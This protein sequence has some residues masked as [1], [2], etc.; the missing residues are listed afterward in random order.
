MVS[1]FDRLP[2]LSCAGCCLLA[3]CLL[4]GAA[5]SAA[6][7][8]D[9][10]ESAE[11]S[12]Q[13][14]DAD[15]PV[16]IEK[17]QRDF[18]VARSGSASEH[19]AITAGRGTFV[20]LVYP[21]HHARVIAEWGPS[22]WVQADRPGMQF[23]ARVVLPRTQ[24]PRNGAP[25]TTLLRGDIYDRVG[26]W[27]Q[28]W[29]HRPDQLLERQVRALRSQ[30]GPDIDAREA[31]VDMVVLNAY[32][33]VGTTQL[34]MDDLEI[35]GQVPVVPPNAFAR[36]DDA[37]GAFPPRDDLVPS[38]P[39]P[40]SAEV[41]LNGSLLTVGG[42]PFF[43]RIIESN[44]ESLESLQ[45]L[46]FNA[47]KLSAA[48]TAVQLREANRLGIW[49]IAPPPN[50]LAI[51]PAH[52]RVLAW[53]LGSGLADPQL[54]LTRQRVANLRKADIRPERVLI[55]EAADRAWSYSRL[56]SFLVLRAA[57]IGTSLSLPRQAQTLRERPTLARPGT[58]VWTAI[59]TE[60]PA[61][62]VDQWSALGLGP[63]PS[64]SGEPEQIRLL[65][66]TAMASGARG[67]IFLSRSPLD[68][69]DSETLG[70][71]RT[72]KQLNLEMQTISPWLV[73]G[74]RL[75][76][77]DSGRD[78]VSVSVL[79]TERAQLL[80]IL[81]QDSNHQYTRGPAARAP[82]SLI[83][84]SAANSPQVY[85]L[86]PGGLRTMT[87]RRVAGG[88]RLTLDEVHLVNLVA[89]AQE[90]LVLN[91]LARSL[92]GSKAEL[93]TLMRDT[94]ASQIE[95]VE[96]IHRQ[97]AGPVSLSGVDP[98]LQQARA[99]LTHCEYLLGV[100]DHAAAYEFAEKALE[101]LAH[102]RRKDWDTA[103]GS[104]ASPS[105]SP[106]CTTLA[107]VP[108]HWE[109]ARR[110][111]AA[112]MWSAN[113]LP[114]GDFESLTHLRQTGW[115]NLAS[116]TRHIV[117]AVELSGNEPS[118][119]NSALRMAATAQE[120]GE[121]PVVFETPP[122]QIVSAPVY[123][124][125]GQLVRWHGSIRIPRPIDRSPDGMK[126]YDSIGGEA[127][128]LRWYETDGWQPFIAYR[129][130]T[131][132]G[133]V[134]LTFELTGLGEVAIDDVEIA[135]HDPIGDGYVNPVLDQARR[136]PSVA[137]GPWIE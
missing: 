25:L 35:R 6:D 111:Q 71:V 115:Q 27:Q 14:T 87:P 10:F 1:Q 12:W 69:T 58:P 24:D 32:G 79:Q 122:L 8:R 64:L 56:A 61:A 51:G 53:D 98:R 75:A 40:G 134:V 33:G 100:L 50:D 80:V 112:P 39:R 62:L 36:S 77:V 49:L 124:R 41:K 125:R 128:A 37:D 52:D 99:N 126:I 120:S 92:A 29:I 4:L 43:P 102:V 63:P 86:T 11:V 3:A 65:A 2:P 116:E 21:I 114:A 129:A 44:G 48:P 76:D 105:A 19:L 30:F 73:A 7:L 70:R 132:D 22:L 130:A 5:P 94:A 119:G 96:S 42:S 72:L 85:R 131:Q 95:L 113:L 54:E 74:T 78:D 28:L 45:A 47:V 93:A 103:A 68:R 23:M 136:L 18:R 34:W 135:V 60:P 46:G 90:P 55:A 89:I 67:L 97:V 110:L 20:Y 59:S 127:L 66:Y 26:A 84:P 38:M 16:R 108:L 83:V 109:M 81:S 107:A 104:F 9:S 137:D 117:T 57:P 118:G 88:I 106:Y 17:H 15:C 101:G 31:Y 13:V 133:Q 82:L 91:H 123:V 121:P